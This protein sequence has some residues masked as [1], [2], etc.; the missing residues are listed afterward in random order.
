MGNTASFKIE[1]SK[2]Q[3]FENFEL[4]PMYLFEMILYIPI[5]NFSVK[6]IFF[7]VEQIDYKQ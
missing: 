2:V 3:D 7:W 6:R 5:I 1:I 4:S